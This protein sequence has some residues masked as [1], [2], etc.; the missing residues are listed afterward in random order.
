VDFNYE[1][2]ARVLKVPDEK[3]R[4]KIYKTIYENLSTVRREIEQVP[5]REDLWSLMA[6]KF[7]EM[8]GPMEKET[9]VDTEWRAKTDELAARFL[10]D[11]WLYQKRRPRAGWEVKIR[12]GVQ[13][14]QKMQKAPGGLIRATTEVQDDAIAA[15]SLSGDFFFFPEEKLADLEA[16]L[17]GVRVEEVEDA[18]ARFYEEHGIESPGVTPADFAQVV[19]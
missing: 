14:K 5:P 6:D 15:L 16:A 9:T 17:V 1:M 7:V 13:V 4:D 2:M 18:I 11:E 19:G 12:A 8:L 3:F 10:T